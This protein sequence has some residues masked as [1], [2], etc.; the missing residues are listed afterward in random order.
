MAALPAR[1]VRGYG[2]LVMGVA[3][4]VVDPT[5]PR[6]PPED[7]WKPM[8]EEERRRV[9]ASLPSEIPRPLPLEG[10]A[11][12]LAKWRALEA[13]DEFF[14][15]RGRSVHLGSEL[16]IYYPGEAVFAPDVIAVL[17]VEPHERESGW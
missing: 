7:V 11:H 2:W 5:D 17:D 1:S 13:L 4:Y 6:A 3:P 16:P 14:R 8:S 15:R 12:R 10:D 9:V